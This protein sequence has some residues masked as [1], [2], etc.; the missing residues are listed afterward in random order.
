MGELSGTSILSVCLQIIDSPLI[1]SSYMQGTGIPLSPTPAG[2]ALWHPSSPWKTVRS[3]LGLVFLLWLT[4]EI[5]AALFISI[6]DSNYN[7]I[8]GPTDPYE[9]LVF[10]SLIHI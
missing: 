8:I 1:V 3:M 9:A 4:A 6:F 7:G 10:L 5:T 2:F